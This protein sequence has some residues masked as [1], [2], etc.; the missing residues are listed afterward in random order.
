MSQEYIHIPVPADRVQEVYEL[1]ARPKA[2]PRV[3]A[4]APVDALTTAMV[5]SREA[6]EQPALVARIYRESPDTMKSMMKA[7]AARAGHGVPM[8]VVAEEVGR[9]PRQM[10][11]ALGAFGRRFKHR[12]SMEATHWPFE[13]WWDY[14]R[15]T[16]VYRMS[17]NVAEVIESLNR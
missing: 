9:A 1:L 2:E 4:D 8:E 11:G 13:A 7:L 17:T 3:I 14:E 15:N 10:A 6:A 12:Y 5:D 16:M